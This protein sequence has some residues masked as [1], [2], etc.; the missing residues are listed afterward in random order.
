M[1]KP[2]REIQGDYSAFPLSVVIAL[3]ATS[4]A[5][6]LGAYFGIGGAVS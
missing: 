2:T 6:A 3:L 5:I 4:S 1:S